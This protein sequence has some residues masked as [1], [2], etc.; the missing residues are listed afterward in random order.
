MNSHRDK[1]ISIIKMK[2][3]N[4]MMTAKL[5]DD[6]WILIS[7]TGEFIRSLHRLHQISMIIDFPRKKLYNIVLYY[8]NLLTFGKCNLIPLFEE[9]VIVETV[10]DVTTS[11]RMFI[12]FFLLD[13]YAKNAVFTPNCF[14]SR[15]WNDSF[16]IL[17]T[18]NLL[19]IQFLI[20]IC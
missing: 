19:S 1:L 18:Y 10:R 12:D 2:S 14:I 8:I 9:S 7:E 20:S 17:N 15:L 6:H 5:S 3:A 13:R 16:L 11:P 4:Q